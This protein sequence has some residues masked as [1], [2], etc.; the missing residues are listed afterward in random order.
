MRHLLPVV[1]LL[2]FTGGLSVAQS[3][4]A[5]F[6]SR[7]EAVNYYAEQE[8]EAWRAN[9]EKLA[10]IDKEFREA[11]T[12]LSEE[13][14]KRLR[15]ISEQNSAEHQALSQQGLS[16]GDRAAE[17]RRIQSDAVQARE[18]LADWYQRSR[19][20]I[21]EEHAQKRAA[22]FDATNA[23]IEKIGEQRAATLR[24]LSTRPPRVDEPPLTETGETR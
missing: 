24:R 7:S 8:R 17:S 14:A 1:G 9:A 22:Q 4:G 15:L 19:R 2:L 18:E 12:A 3:D 16:S 21:N 13:N 5:E 20:A 11:M 10:D 23:L 6:P